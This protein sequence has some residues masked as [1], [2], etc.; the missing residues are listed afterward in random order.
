M[1]DSIG[2]DNVYEGLGDVIYDPYANLLGMLMT[3]NLGFQKDGV[4]T[5]EE[6]RSLASF[7]PFVDSLWNA[8]Y[9]DT[10]NGYLNVKTLA[11]IGDDSVWAVREAKG[12]GTSTYSTLSQ[13]CLR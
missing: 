6:A 10:R 3:G 5:F 11:A 4:L 9:R 1:C 8:I 2:T 13:E 12:N 7:I